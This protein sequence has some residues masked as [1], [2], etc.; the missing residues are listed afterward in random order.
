MEAGSLVA[1]ALV[2]RKFGP[3]QGVLLAGGF[4]LA[5]LVG[6]VLAMLIWGIGIGVKAADLAAETHGK[7]PLHIPTPGVG[8]LAVSVLTGYVLAS[9]WAIG[10]SLYV[11]KPLLR[12]GDALGLGWRGAEVRGYLVA[13]GL[14][15]AVVA[16]AV[17]LARLV[18]PDMAKLTGPAEQLSR[19]HGWPHAVLIV[20][21]LGMAPFVEEFAFR[22]TI[23]AAFAQRFHVMTAALISTLLFVIMHAADKI[24][25]WP[26]F[27]DVGL[28]GLA[29]AYVRLRSRS[30]RPAMLL[31]LLY[32]GGLVALPVAFH[33]ARLM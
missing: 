10:Y 9:A 33:M 5:T 8:L 4:F 26:G 28:L 12:V 19:S 15:L 25:Y 21:M 24:H 16:V 29:C 3:G 18:P 20:L 31:H 6:S 11:A 23:I 2:P 7:G 1:S 14:S 17:G 32:N 22:G 13:A 27:I 30:V